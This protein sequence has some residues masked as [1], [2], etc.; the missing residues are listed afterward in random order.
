[1]LKTILRKMMLVTQTGNK[2]VCNLYSVSS[3]V[4][5]RIV[6]ERKT[7]ADLKQYRRRVCAPSF[8]LLETG[9]RT[10]LTSSMESKMQARELLKIFRQNNLDSA[11]INEEEKNLENDDLEGFYLESLKHAGNKIYENARIVFKNNTAV[12]ASQTNAK[13]VTYNDL[14]SFLQAKILN[15]SKYDAVVLTIPDHQLNWSDRYIDNSHHALKPYEDEINSSEDVF[16]TILTI[17]SDP[18]SHFND[19]SVARQQHLLFMSKKNRK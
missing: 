10:A 15:I 9:E 1:M 17:L 11:F 16:K 19:T 12:T 3:T 4:A 13:S 14:V 7:E 18:G 5:S 6:N 8:M 2:L